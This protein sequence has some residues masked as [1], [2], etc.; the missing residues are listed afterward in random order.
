MHRRFLLSTMVFALTLSAASAMAASKIVHFRLH[1]AL[2]ESPSSGDFAALLGETKPNTFLRL[3]RKMDRAVEDPD[4][5]AVVITMESPAI[6]L[7]QVMELREAIARFKTVGKEVYCH[8][9]SFSPWTSYLV[10]AA[11]SH[12]AMVP[13]GDLPLTGMNAEIGFYKGL[14][15]KVGLQADIVHIGEFK[16]AGEPYSR[17]APSEAFQKQM[18]RLYD[19][20]YEQIVSAIADSRG[21]TKAKVTS[22]IDNGPYSAKTALEAGLIDAVTYRKEFVDDIR[23]R[24]PGAEIDSNYGE[25]AAPEIDFN[26]PFALFTEL[27]KLFQQTQGIEKANIAVIYVDGMIMGGKSNES[28]LGGASA[29]SSTIR[30]ALEKAAEDPMVKAVV[31]RV[32]SP[33]GAVTASEIIWR[34]TQRVAN[35][36]PLIVSMGNVAASGGYYVSCGANAI[37]ADPATLTGSIGVVGGKVVSRDLWEK[38]G[39][40]TF[41]LRRGTNADLYSGEQPFTEAQR[42]KIRAY[43]GNAYEIFKSRVTAG[44]SDKLSGDLEGLAGGR[45]YTGREALSNG[46]VDRMGGLHDAIVYAAGEARIGEY[47]VQVLPKT[48]TFFDLLMESM[49]GESDE[50]KL[51]FAPAFRALLAGPETSPIVQALQTIDP[52]GYRALLAHVQRLALLQQEQVIV[53]MPFDVRI[54]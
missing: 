12:V 52:E 2:R 32:D 36:K 5:K 18:N 48:K 10:A 47:E 17:E 46:L 49:T 16:G 39:V 13:T 26:N 34:A 35:R 7:A 8:V 31:L 29:G 43:M 50:D 38:L 40:N 20:I 27:N 6:G 14:M 41:S 4:V 3:M 11:C 21:L 9:E 42:E 25:E 53:A 23:K 33:G 51:M 54:R 15:D 44:R 30:R 45:V 19:D 37:F 1:G 22:I 24:H 28:P